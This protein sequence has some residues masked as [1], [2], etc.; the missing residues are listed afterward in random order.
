MRTPHN[1]ARLAPI[2][3]QYA[4]IVQVIQ[5]LI[6]QEKTPEQVLSDHDFQLE[7]SEAYGLEVDRKTI[8]DLRKDKNIPNSYARKFLLKNKQKGSK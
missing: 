3:Q 1:I 2:H 6:K 4:R 8:C 5:N 7:L